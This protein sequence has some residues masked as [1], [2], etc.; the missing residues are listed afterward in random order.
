VDT[1]FK[2]QMISDYSSVEGHIS[3]VSRSGLCFE[4]G[5]ELP[6]LLISAS[7]LR[8]GKASGVVVISFDVPVPNAESKPVIAQARTVYVIDGD[9]G[10]YRCGAEFI[11]FA[12]GEEAFE[13]YLR[14][15]TAAK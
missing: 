9:G 1:W 6:D 11:V 13:D 10:N 4:A 7:G 5:G 15:R 3:N 2:A 12:E 8:A 14:A